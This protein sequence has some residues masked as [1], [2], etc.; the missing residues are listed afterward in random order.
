MDPVNSLSVDLETNEQR[1]F[2]LE[3]RQNYDL[4]KTEK[5]VD[6]LLKIF[7][8]YGVKTT[9]FV[10]AELYELRPELIE[11]IADQ[12]HEIG[13]HTHRHR[14]LRSAADLT[15]ELKLSK[16]FLRKFQPS[17][18]R[19][20]KMYF[21]KEYF[22]ILAARGFKYDSSTYDCYSEARVYAGVK[23]L[24]VSLTGPAHRLNIPFPRNFRRSLIKG[25]PWGSGLV[26]SL[27]PRLV[28]LLIDRLNRKGHTAIMFVHPWQLDSQGKGLYG[29]NATM[30]IKRILFGKR[31][32]PL[33]NLI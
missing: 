17:G 26:L 15:E 21:K 30:A 24:P 16:K 6:R 33:K 29:R 9:F 25:I 18:F 20:P 27:I 28:N 14:L 13:Y 3:L 22:P 5:Q 4:I 2:N 8:H 31:F 11:R 19:A 12:G 32:G 10:A 1:Q 7:N 23:E